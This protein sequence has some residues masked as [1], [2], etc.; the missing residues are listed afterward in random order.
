VHGLCTEV[1]PESSHDICQAFSIKAEVLSGEEEEEDPLTIPFPEIK[2]E[3][4]VSCVTLY[5]LG[6]FHKYRYSV[7]LQTFST[8][9]NLHL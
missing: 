8:V 6:V 2:A 3:P 4:E 9:N 5:M 1:C 7:F